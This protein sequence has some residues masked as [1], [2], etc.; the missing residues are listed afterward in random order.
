MCTR[1]KVLFSVLAEE[2]A[3]VVATGEVTCYPYRPSA[4]P[5][6]IDFAISECFR[7]QQI[8]VQVLTELSSDH[9]P[10]LFEIDED[11]QFFKG[12]KIMLSLLGNIEVF[13]E[14]IE[15][16]VQLSIPIDTCRRFEAYVD[17][18]TSIIAEA[19]RR[20]TPTP[21]LAGFT[22]GRRA[23]ILGA[24]PDDSSDLSIWRLTKGIKRQPLF[25]SPIHSN[26]V[27]WLRTGD[28]KANA[29]A[30]HL[31]SNHE[32]IANFLDDPTA[33]VRPMRHTTP[34]E[35]ML[36]LKALQPKKK[37]LGTMAST[38]VPRNHCYAKVC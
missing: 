31:S 28:E 26:S 32:A 30:S 25:Q 11:A 29:F 35:V 1:G 9:L 38:T 3:E 19:A 23:P 36:Q 21:H 15:N 8:M 13:K 4:T 33:P 6:A 18:C 27:L 10:L 7:Q 5:S 22:S 16:T 14:H 24:G 34:Q 17:Y 20:A 12:V 2:G 37:P